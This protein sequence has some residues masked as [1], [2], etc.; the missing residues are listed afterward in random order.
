MTGNNAK[1]AL[2]FVLTGRQTTDV[3]HYFDG[4]E[5]T[6]L[7]YDTQEPNRGPTM[8]GS[9]FRGFGSVFRDHD[10]PLS[11]NEHPTLVTL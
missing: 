6:D 11:E 10:Y 2:F 5:R 1:P 3:S 4:A 9:K 7:C 8:I